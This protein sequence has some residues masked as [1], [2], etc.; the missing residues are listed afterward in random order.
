ME[1]VEDRRERTG[2][3]FAKMQRQ[4]ARRMH[5]DPAFAEMPGDELERIEASGRKRSRRTRR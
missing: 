1:A 4:F 3:A 2:R 5:N